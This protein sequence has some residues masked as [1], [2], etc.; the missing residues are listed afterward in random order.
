MTN[1]KFQSRR[2]LAFTCTFLILLI[3]CGCKDDARAIWKSVIKKCA[4]NDLLGRDILFFGPS[5]NLGPGTIL[6]KFTEGGGGIQVSHLF[7]EYAS[8]LESLINRGQAFSCEGMSSSSTK[9]GTD[10]SLESALSITGNLGVEL[11]R[12]KEISVK[13]NSAQWVDIIT[14]PFR[15]QVLGL[16]DDNIVKKDLLNNGHLVMSRALRV[17]GM[18]AELSF[19]IEIGGELKAKFPEINIVAG[20]ADAGVGLNGE[21]ISETKLVINSTSD[22]Y[23]AGELREFLVTGLAAPSDVIGP[24]EQNVDKLKFVRRY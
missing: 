1:Q 14:G 8:D 9:I 15:Q 2:I 20:P 11:K 17:Q 4:N 23:I 7:S 19:S 24:I 10:L 21:W 5:N 22:F 3:C 12:A 16:S 6:Q 13:V 18:S